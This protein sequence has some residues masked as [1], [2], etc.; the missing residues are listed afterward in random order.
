MHDVG[1]IGIADKII[2]KPGK[3]S[4]EEFEI[5]K[6]HTIIGG[7]LLSES[8]SDILKMAKQI[9]LCHHEKYNGTGYPKGLSKEEIPLAARIVAIVDTFDALTSKRPYKDPYPPEIA[10]NI[11]KAERGK[12]FDP[13]ITDL[14]VE[15]FDKFLK[16]RET[17][18]GLEEVDLE[19]FFLSERDQALLDENKT[20]S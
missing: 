17:T 16:V 15:H 6:T 2:L 20:L 7:E 5:I 3:L 18:G 13:H 19:N 12:H 10:L 1:K 14:F 4:H 8:K 11:I 9:A